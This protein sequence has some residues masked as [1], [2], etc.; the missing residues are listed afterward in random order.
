VL[1]NALPTPRGT[2]ATLNANLPPDHH[3]VQSTPISYLTP[4][5]AIPRTPHQNTF[6]DSILQDLRNIA[7]TH[8]TWDTQHGTLT[9]TPSPASHLPLPNPL[10]NYSPSSPRFVDVGSG[11][12]E[13]MGLG[14]LPSPISSDSSDSSSDCTAFDHR[15]GVT[16][17]PLI[18]LNPLE[19]NLIDWHV[20][21]PAR[22]ARHVED[23]DTFLANANQSATT[24]P[25]HTLHID[26]CFLDQPGVRWN[27][28]P[29]TI[30]KRRSIRITDILHSIHD[31][32]QTQLT[33][34]EYDAIKSHGKRNSRIVANSFRERVTLQPSTDM[35]DEAYHGGLRRVDCLGSCKIFAGLWVEGLQLT[36]GLRQ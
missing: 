1:V 12:G 17:H 4:I 22:M 33:H 31:Y 2:C 14:L 23:D 26:I 16:L 10:V 19:G 21:D 20:S 6:P 5:S 28:E 35:R 30:N 15:F 18:A 8:L 34:A 25:T 13:P 36:L 27:W 11:N 7:P 24:P 3:I 32:F 29:I 9:Y